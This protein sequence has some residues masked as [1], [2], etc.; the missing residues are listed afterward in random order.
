MNESPTVFVHAGWRCAS[1]Y[2]WSRFRALPATTCFYEPFGERLAHVSAKRIERDT[3]QGWDSRHPALELPYRAEYRPLLRRLRRGVAGYRESFAIERYFPRDAARRE[4]AYLTRLTDF[5]RRRGTVPVLGF[6]RSLARAAALKAGMGG[7]HIVLRRTAAQQWMSCRSFR[8]AGVPPYFELCHGLILAR[9]PAGSPAGHLA[10]HLGLPHLPAWT[11]G[12]TREVR[13]LHAALGS[14]SD[15]R[16][17]EVFIA[18]YLLSQAAAAPVA[19]LLLD[20]DRLGTSTRYRDEM[21]ERLRVG[22]A[23]PVDFSC[24]RTP[25]YATADVAVDFE[26]VEAD[27]RRRLTAFGAKLDAAGDIQ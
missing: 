18:V 4:I 22:T 15:V 2:V 25:S 10:T 8:A 5:A 27:I 16:S 26:A 19:D 7:Y 21:T 14:W 13:A 11:R 12:V 6:S 3:A 20:V 9:A 17:Y 24:S 1:T 23:L